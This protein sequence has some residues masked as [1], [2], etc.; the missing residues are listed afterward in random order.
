VG[1]K[2]TLGSPKLVARPEALERLVARLAK[3]S[4]VAFDTEAASFHR[5]VDRVYL[6]QVSAGKETALVDPLA[7]DDLSPLGD[8]LADPAIEIVFHDADYDL[9]ILDRDF[10][11][12]A[13]NLF[14]TRIAAQ[15]AGEPQLGLGALIEKH[16]SVTVN[17][18][19]QRADWSRRPLTAEM[20][21]YAAD[22][23]RFLPPLRDK[24]S[25][26]LD[27]M[28]R[29]AWAREEFRLLEKIR[30]TQPVGDEMAFTRVK[31]AK[32]LPPRALAI[33]RELHAW[34]EQMAQSLDRAPFRVLSNSAL[35]ATAQAAPRDVARLHSVS[36]LPPSAA[37]R[38]GEKLVEAVAK[39]LAVPRKE[40]PKIK[41]S[42]RPE[43]DHAYDTRL[44]RLKS[45]RNRRA[46]EFSMQ[47]GTLCPNG[48]LQAIARG[49]PT[50]ESQ[51][52]GIAELREWQT[53]VLGIADI[54]E[55]TR[56]DA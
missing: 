24:L 42:A 28:D 23:T 36:G 7:I 52:G 34:R 35:L 22:D 49:A 43:H 20:I 18:K 17:K 50:K 48:T 37:R 9:R 56:S 47:P 8:I 54:L 51:L 53:S 44:D 31:G 26:E 33:L 30:W 15:F 12:T 29:L 2:P 21:E 11:F 10:G 6:V 1:R 41:R 4:Q 39:G 19:L 46:E 55:A 16:F 40:L 13:K 32:A 5:Y 14:D 45:L 27:S 25:T 3:Q 38:Y